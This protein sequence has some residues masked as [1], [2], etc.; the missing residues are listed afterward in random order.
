M[1]MSVSYVL[2]KRS[3]KKPHAAEQIIG[4]DFSP[5]NNLEVIK[6]VPGKFWGFLIIFSSHTR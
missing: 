3:K 2:A 1:H 4:K 5:G 6:P